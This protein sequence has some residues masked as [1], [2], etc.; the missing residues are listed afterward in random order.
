MEQKVLGTPDTGGIMMSVSFTAHA[1]RATPLPGDHCID[2]FPEGSQKKGIPCPAQVSSASL[3]A[4]GAAPKHPSSLP[5]HNPALTDS[6]L[7]AAETHSVSFLD[8]GEPSSKATQD[9]TARTSVL[10][11]VESI[12]CWAI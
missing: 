11:D 10:R 7:L 8:H 5:H 4:C 1:C 12:P 2:S 3:R 6:T 9:S